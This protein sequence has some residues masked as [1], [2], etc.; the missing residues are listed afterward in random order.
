MD[1]FVAVEQV[2]CRDFVRVVVVVPKN[3]PVADIGLVTS[4]EAVEYFVPV[5]YTDS[6]GASPICFY[7]P[8]TSSLAQLVLLGRPHIILWIAKLNLFLIP[9]Y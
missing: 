8:A 2:V 5:A 1:Y 7:L 9:F 6:V 3:V 4:V